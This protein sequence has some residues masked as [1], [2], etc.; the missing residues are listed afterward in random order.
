MAPYN[1][2]SY[3]NKAVMQNVNHTENFAIEGL[4]KIFF[5]SLAAA[6]IVFSL[7]KYIGVTF[8]SASY[9]LVAFFMVQIIIFSLNKFNQIKDGSAA[10]KNP[11]NIFLIFLSVATGLITAS[12]NRPDIDDSVYA[13]KAVFF[14][15]NPDSQLS[16]SITWIEGL[17][18]GSDSFVFQYYEIFQASFAWF[19]GVKFLAVY[20]VL[21]PFIVGFLSF[22]AIYLLL[23]LFYRDSRT[24]LAGAVFFV[25]LTLLLGETHRTY[26]N[27]S[28]ARAF[29]GKYV[30]FY[31][32]FYFWIYVSIKYFIDRKLGQVVF[33]GVTGVALTVLTTTAFV[34]IPLLSVIIYLAFFGS[35]G[36]L[37]TVDTLRVGFGYFF[38]LIPTAILALNFRSEALRVMPKGSSINAGFS[39]D[40]RDQVGYLVNIDFPITPILFFVSLLLVLLLSENRKFFG[41]WILI[42]LLLIL[43]PLTSSFVMKY[44][45][46][47]N[48]YW[49]M[50]YLLPFPLIAVIAF[51][52][53]IEKVN[54]YK[55]S[56]F[57]III[58]MII[59]VFYLPSSV[60][61]RDNAAYLEFLSYKIHEPTRSFVQ[62]FERTLPPGSCFCPVDVA[63]NL[64]IYS[65]KF[66]QFYLREDYLNLVVERY[67][68]ADQAQARRNIAAYLY[69][70][71]TSPDT[72][73]SFQMMIRMGGPDYVVL[74][75]DSLNTL[76]AANF[77]SSTGYNKMDL[78]DSRYQL[79]KN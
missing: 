69:S 13:P 59:S 5:T 66:P 21:F 78:G 6:L 38:A 70:A 77:L 65:S 26:G 34:F 40:F 7:G 32:G 20:H 17:P 10:K 11:E 68:S 47:E 51:C 71:S 15:E 4:L 25:L 41:I 73:S 56:V 12:I 75:N 19:F 50:F 14:T 3:G 18:E 62:A 64:V 29:H 44:L 27:L 31:L 2:G 61:R 16:D 1:N 76:E 79:W 30:L 36:N 46:T 58:S 33:L 72:K 42:P 60:L 43:N 55:I 23:G 52:G 74:V 63:S 28:I 37:F 48:A 22:C 39:A 67:L 35:R 54:K 49:R 57:G 24:K 45:T 8:R 53:F 9:L